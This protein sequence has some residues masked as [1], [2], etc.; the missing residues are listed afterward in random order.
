MSDSQAVYLTVSLLITTRFLWVVFQI[1]TLCA[2]KT[3][4]DIVRTLM[5]LPQDLGET[6]N[7][8]LRK[9][10]MLGEPN[11]TYVQKIFWWVAIAREPL[12]VDQLREA[13]TV[14]PADLDW[15]PSCCI[16]DMSQILAMCGC[17]VTVDEEYG[18]VQFTHHSVKQHLTST[19][20]DLSVKDYQILAEQ[21]EKYAGEVCI[22]YLNSAR[23]EGQL[24]RMPAVRR[25]TTITTTG[26][27]NTALSQSSVTKRL[28]LQLLKSKS[29]SLSF[30]H[31]RLQTM[32]IQTNEEEQIV[33]DEFPLKEYANKYWLHHTKFLRVPFRV[34]SFDVEHL[35][36]RYGDRE[37]KL[38]RLWIKMVKDKDALRKVMGL[39]TPDLCQPQAMRWIVDHGNQALLRY[40]LQSRHFDEEDP[41]LE[42]DHEK[43]A[44]LILLRSDSS[45]EEALLKH[46]R[47]MTLPLLNKI[48]VLL[49][50]RGDPGPFLKVWH[51]VNPEWC[52]TWPIFALGDHAFR[53]HEIKVTHPSFVY[54]ARKNEESTGWGPLSLAAA[55][56]HADIC[57]TIVDPI[58]ESSWDRPTWIYS[59]EGKRDLCKAFEEAAVH[60]HV[61]IAL[62][63]C[64]N[65]WR[66]SL[67]CQ[68][69]HYYYQGWTPLMLAVSLGNWRL[70]QTFLDQGVNSRHQGRE[71]DKAYNLALYFCWMDIAKSLRELRDSQLANGEKSEV[72]QSGAQLQPSTSVEEVSYS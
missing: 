61:D 32:A 35:A 23:F 53:C 24:I 67:I 59:V 55:Y 45:L 25:A 37:A 15:D 29:K 18:T 30:D 40:K 58:D 49:A 43:M 9:V 57:A 20:A 33:P 48:L 63:L 51:S 17:L 38:W 8:I 11:I 69:E 52:V 64:S 21:V 68:T 36:R 62:A 28:A 70:I 4:A 12:T 44:E 41:I 50:Q 13:L 5:N 22:T 27:V 34:G 47:I 10:A 16:N 6:F 19:I 2:Q 66:L 39:S 54:H 7:H 46:F 56:G 3:D 42:A 14:E 60:G 31:H 71:L 65:S 26:I 1:S 72:S